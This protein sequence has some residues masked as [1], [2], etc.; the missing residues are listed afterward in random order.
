[1]I[2]KNLKN[3][4]LLVLLCTIAESRHIYE[5][6]WG[7]LGASSRIRNSRDLSKHDKNELPSL[8]I[9]RTDDKTSQTEKSSSNDSKR[10]NQ[11]KVENHGKN[12][13]DPKYHIDATKSIKAEY[14]IQNV[15]NRY[16]CFNKYYCGNITAFYIAQSNTFSCENMYLDIII[17]I[18]VLDA[19]NDDESPYILA[20]NYQAT[21]FLPPIGELKRDRLVTEQCL[22]IKQ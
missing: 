13:A 19:R 17:D 9:A 21:A 1:M 5:N 14:Y 3:A 22:P 15:E 7:N 10:E 4:I 8:H 20:T 6:M 12:H 18:Q 16:I 2:K 11:Q